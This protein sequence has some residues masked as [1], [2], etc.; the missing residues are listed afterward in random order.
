M[1]YD[2]MSTGAGSAANV[3]ATH[4]FE[5]KNAPDPAWNQVYLR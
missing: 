2:A 3:L 1:R 4:P 5:T